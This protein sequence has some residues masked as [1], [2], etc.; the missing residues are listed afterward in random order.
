[1]NTGIIYMLYSLKTN[2]HYIGFTKLTINNCL[3]AI[4]SRYKLFKK[5]NPGYVYTT[6]YSILE[7][8]QYGIIDISTETYDD[9]RDVHKKMN[10]Y[11]KNSNGK[12][13]NRMKYKTKEDLKLQKQQ[14]YNRKKEALKVKRKL[15][16]LFTAPEKTSKMRKRNMQRYL[17]RQK[18]KRVQFGDNL[19]K[20]NG[21][22]IKFD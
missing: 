5:G 20:Q 4:E 8:G 12:C 17:K 3:R 7:A 18:K 11:I 19:I 15:R 1:M 13:I 21:L 16:E 9:I 22:T 6:V 2:K 10:A 14:Y